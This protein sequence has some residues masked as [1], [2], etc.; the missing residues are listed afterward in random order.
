MNCYLK[1][2]YGITNI[3]NLLKYE[4]NFLEIIQNGKLLISTYILKITNLCV[5]L[6][7]FSAFIKYV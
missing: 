1:A 3:M 7:Y 6:K 4:S 5:D 2:E